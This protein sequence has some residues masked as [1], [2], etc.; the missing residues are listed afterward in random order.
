MPGQ[1]E[2]LLS[3][4]PDEEGTMSLVTLR[5]WVC[6]KVALSGSRKGGCTLHHLCGLIRPHKAG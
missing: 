2:Q 3:L 6:V 5:L 4:C 1:R